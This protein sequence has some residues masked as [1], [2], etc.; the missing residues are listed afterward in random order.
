MKYPRLAIFI[1]CSVLLGL[2]GCSSPSSSDF[3]IIPAIVNTLQAGGSAQQESS[4][5]ATPPSGGTAASS[6]WVHPALPLSLLQNVS[7]PDSFSQE[8]QAGAADVRIE[9]GEQN[10][11]SRWVYALVAPFPTII[12]GVSFEEI[13]DAWVGDPSGHFSGQPLLMDED[14]LELFS[15]WWGE[16]ADGAVRTRS[17]SRLLGY[18]WDHRP[19]WAL[20]P[21]EE[22]S[23]NWKVLQVDGLS[24]LF[25]EF[26]PENYSL[27]LPVSLH[28]TDQALVGEL[29]LN[30]GPGSAKPLMRPSNRDASKLT[31]LVMTGVTALARATAWEMENK[32][33]NFP[34]EYVGEF[35]ASADLTHI[36]N[37]VPFLES[38]PPP[39]PNQTSLVFCSHPRYIELLITVGADVIELTGDHFGDWG[40]KGMEYTLRLYDQMG[41][42]YYGGGYNDELA[43]Q[44]VL[45]EHNGNRLAFIGCNGKGGG[46]STAGED[47][48]GAVECDYEWLA[49]E[50][51]HLRGEGYLVIMTFQHL[52]Y[53]NY[54]PQALQLRDFRP[55]AEAGAVIV[56]GS[57]A[58]QAQGIEFLDGGVIFYGLGNLFFDQLTVTDETARALIVRHVFYDGRHIS[59]ELF[60]II[61]ETYSQPR[62]MDAEERQDLLAKV[63]EGSGW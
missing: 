47:E 29:N 8:S 45:L 39:D 10:I 14:T 18:A 33:I 42:P 19:S 28:G 44:A 23:P 13:K 48:P 56:S 49:E 30:Y 5:Q 59:S 2:A 32:G 11:Y 3:P 61:F 27:S 50:I 9:V 1:G 36:S 38:C 51:S 46:Y 7:L 62:F 22:L 60:T 16:P 31:T 52:E 40:D 4:S 21:F 57:Q 58:H 35:L 17:S 53:Y 20:V 12:D 15:L 43:R 41:W 37:E 26:D 6:V 34:A 25:Q 63:F 54:K 55:M 24:P